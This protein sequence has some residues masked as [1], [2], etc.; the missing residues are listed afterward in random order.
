MTEN[1]T[2]K[3]MHHQ[4]RDIVKGARELSYEPWTPEEDERLKQEYA[5]GIKIPQIAEMH[6]RSSGAIRSR[7]KK[8]RMEVSSSA[9]VNRQAN[10]T[11]TDSVVER[12][13]KV[14]YPYNLLSAAFKCP[15]SELPE[16]PADIEDRL[17]ILF[18]NKDI[19]AREIMLMRYRDGLTLAK[20]GESYGIGAERVR[21]IV[22]KMLGKVGHSAKRAYLTD[23]TIPLK[24]GIKGI[25][26]AT[27]KITK[28]QLS[29][30]EVSDEPITVS[31]MARR[32]NSAVSFSS[33]YKVYRD[34]IYS[35]LRA[36]E[37]IDLIFEEGKR[38]RVPTEYGASIGVE[39]F[40]YISEAGRNRRTLRLS[41]EAQIFILENMLQC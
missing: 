39:V 9:T 6:E 25:E 10:P 33:G 29:E 4:H 34:D 3:Y 13:K 26:R 30:I 35:F 28:E 7:L 11:E 14:N 1:T 40:N 36:N 8:N 31:E 17:Q 20:I 41:K 18:D 2:K 23:G 5:Q 24:A 21:Q 15:V 32:I 16:L 38:T 37:A 12:T 27:I 22:N 19:R